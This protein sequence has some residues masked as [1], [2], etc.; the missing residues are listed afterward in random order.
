M[1]YKSHFRF[2]KQERSGIFFLLLILVGFQIGYF[3]LKS[4]PFSGPTHFAL[5]EVEQGQLDSLRA[6][7]IVEEE[8]IFPFN[9]NYILD[10]KG[11]TLGMSPE[12]LDRLHTYREQGKFVNSVEEFQQ[13]THISDS[14]LEL[15][16]P[17]FKFP[18]WKNSQA[19][20]QKKSAPNKTTVIIKDLNKATAEELESVYGIGATLSKRIIKFRDRL[21]GFLVNEQLYDV[22]GLQPEVVEKTLR[23]FQV[24][25]VPN[26][27]KINLN[28]ADVSQ[29]SQLIYIPK[30][31]AYTI[32]EYR[33]L[34]GAFTSFQELGNVDGFPAEKL[35]RIALYLS[36]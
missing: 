12:E 14:L 29:L 26:V 8:K 16:S 27:N 1:I 25:M 3:Y 28:K 30:S 9:P 7:L 11:Y 18:Q 32:I 10:Y 20:S 13:I 21:G 24:K 31:L 4:K 2:N 17:S 33:N 19:S 5:N 6:Q 34:K 23:N 22:Y 15:I 35:D 36:L